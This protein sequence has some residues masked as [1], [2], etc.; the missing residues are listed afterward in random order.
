MRGW[1]CAPRHGKSGDAL[2][3]WGVGLQATGANVPLAPPTEAGARLEE[4]RRHYPHS[5]HFD[6]AL[7]R[8]GPSS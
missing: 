7:I 8:F 2:L 6:L 3:I 4:A 1:V 5:L